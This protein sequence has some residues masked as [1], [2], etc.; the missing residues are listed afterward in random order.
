MSR[1]LAVVLSTD[2]T[3]F[4]ERVRSR[5]EAF[6][7]E[8]RRKVVAYHKKV[9]EM[10]DRVQNREFLCTQSKKEEA[11][12]AAKKKFHQ[13]IAESGLDVKNFTDSESETENYP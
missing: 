6:L 4:E 7:A 8:E 5:R 1:K 12:K 10:N 9:K 13:T 11:L 3:E 2:K